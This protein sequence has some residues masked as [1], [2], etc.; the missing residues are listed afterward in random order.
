MLTAFDESKANATALRFESVDEASK[1]QR[2][3]RMI[4]R[5]IITVFPIPVYRCRRLSE[6]R[7]SHGK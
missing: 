6:A 7:D 3:Q 1:R 5:E 2:Q 4:E